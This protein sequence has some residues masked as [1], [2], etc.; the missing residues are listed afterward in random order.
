MNKRLKLVMLG[1]GLMLALS[2]AVSG[3]MAQS[4]AD[5]KVRFVHAIPG[6]AA[7][8]VYTDGQLTV[9]GLEY[10]TATT[11][12]SIPAGD[13]QLTV[14]QTG[15]TT[16]LWEQTFSAGAASAQTL[17]AASPSE[18]SF[19]V[20]PDDL[21]PLPLGKA[22][23]TIAHAI[24]GGPA[25]DL[26]LA[27]GRP[28][29]PGVEAGVPSGTLDIPAMTY[30]FTVVPAGEAPANALVVSEPLS[31]SSGTSYTLLV[32]S[33]TGS[34]ATLLLAAPTAPEA[35]GGFVR[36][37]HTA[38]G[39]PAVDIFVNEALTIPG[40]AFGEA[41]EH[42]AVPAGTY[43][44]AVRGEGQSEDWLTTSL[45][46]EAGQAVTVA[47]LGNAEELS[48]G[49]FTDDISAPDALQAR[50]SLINAISGEA[51]ISATLADG[52]ELA[53]G[54]ASG[55]AAPAVNIIPTTSTITVSLDAAED[56][57]EIPAQAFY[58]GVYYNLIAVDNEG[59]IELISAPTSLS[60]SI[61][62]APGS[63]GSIVV[64]ATEA[65][66]EPPPVVAEA[67]EAPVV[68]VEPT[69]AQPTVA[70]PTPAPVVTT[71]AG[72]TGRVFNLNANA[73]LQLRQYP[74]SQALSLGTI[75][76]NTILTVNG[77]A[78]EIVPLPFSATPLPPEDYEFVDPATLLE[79]R[80][81][82]VP[83]E[84]W[85]NVTYNTPDGGSITAW[86]N[87]LYIDVRDA[88]GDSVLLRDLPLV[89]ANLPGEA[90]N[91][92]ITAPQGRPDVILAIVTNL[93]ATTNVNIRR[94]PDQTSEALARVGN[95]T[96]LEFVGISEAG[97]WVFVRYTAPEGGAV[98]GWISPT[99]LRF[100][101]NQQPITIEGIEERGLLVVTPLTTIGEQSAGTGP[102]SIPTADPARDAIIAQVS[103]DAGSNL[104]LR[105]APNA[106]AEVLLQL[107]SGTR[108]IVNGRTGDGNWLSVSY[109]GTDGWIAART[110]VAVFVNLSLNGRPVP[111]A[112][113]PLAVGEV[114]AT[115][116]PDATAEPGATA[117]PSEGLPIDPKPAVI[118]DVTVAMTG[119][120]GGENQG[121]PIL[122]RG[123]QVTQLFSDGTFAYIENENGIRGWVPAGAVFV[124]AVAP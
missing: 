78:G 84:T 23:F 114:E 69:V 43:D 36:L 34:A 102:V 47:V 25:V 61:A 73:N 74:N 17:V 64:E 68:A 76:S 37:V 124:Q 16:P 80:E 121:L 118:T 77:R 9:S 45:T 33:T 111:L 32:H 27:D 107:P 119:S 57:V 70:A 91:T 108:V 21:N 51:A 44:I 95:D 89:S 85:L 109:E 94:T 22:R 92:A 87:A 58:G 90:L 2:L 7:I 24:P 18:A 8:D 46:V 103:L 49:I 120:P 112:D 54:L 106:S 71:P 62:S 12:A 88:D 48:G 82:L 116:D 6:A 5:A 35:D 26:V 63:S 72:P 31:L 15:S 20:F 19:L 86:G 115:A 42:I 66:V 67:T 79:E 13:H 10:A 96:A 110:D 97:D 56:S 52:R 93:D 3:V 81:D 100:E 122:S 99:Y 60:Q 4:A 30:D 55:E 98:T 11:F 65:V 1:L 29:I 38:A 117:T 50:L 75:P 83:E 113:V 123:Q 41:T 40:L 39:A 28:V 101:Y 105:R 14:T 53:T 59:T 104:N